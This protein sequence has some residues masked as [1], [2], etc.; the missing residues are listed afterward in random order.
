MLRIVIALVLFAHAVGH[1]LGPLQ[2]LNISTVKSAWQGDSWLLTGLGPTFNQMLGLVVWTVA[3]AGFVAAAAVVLNWLPADW[4]AP[5]AIGSAVVSLA[6]ILLYPGVLPMF[7][8]VGAI[9]VDLVVLLS[10]TWLHLT[11]AALAD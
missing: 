10:A 8:L 7:S 2:M 5:L 9:T 4:W 11:P 3:L 1:I 6:C